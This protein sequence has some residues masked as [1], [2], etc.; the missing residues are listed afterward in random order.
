MSR[1]WTLIIALAVVVAL[2]VGLHAGFFRPRAAEWTRR[3]ERAE[4]N[5]AEYYRIVKSIPDAAVD[6]LPAPADDGT[7]GR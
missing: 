2:S 3:H 7:S 1:R 5:A 4:R 6:A